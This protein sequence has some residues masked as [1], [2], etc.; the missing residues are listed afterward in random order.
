MFAGRESERGGRH[1]CAQAV[2]PGRRSRRRPSSPP[3]RSHGDLPD[4]ALSSPPTM[5]FDPAEHPHRRCE[6]PRAQRPLLRSHTSSEPAHGRARPRLAP[7]HQA[8]L[9]GPD[10]AASSHDP[11]RLRPGMLPLPGQR[12]R[13]RRAQPALHAHGPLHERLRGGAP[14]ARAR[15]AGPAAPA[16]HRRARQR[17]VR[18]ARVSPAARPHA[19]APRARGRRADRGRVDRGVRRARARARRRV[20]A[21]IRGAYSTLRSYTHR[22]TRRRTR[23]R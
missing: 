14:A 22:P 15:A 9:A 4:I 18:R 17:R 19:R 1:A 2:Q 13:G 11:P 23:A 6:Y 8:A 5:D 3:R 12:A 16:A 7:P 20:R 21:D 10:R